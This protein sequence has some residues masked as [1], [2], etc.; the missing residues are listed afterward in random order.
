[1]LHQHHPPQSTGDEDVTEVKAVSWW[2]RVIDLY[3]NNA[4]STPPTTNPWFQAHRVIVAWRDMDAS[5]GKIEKYTNYN[6]IKNL[7]EYTLDGCS[8]KLHYIVHVKYLLKPDGGLQSR[9]WIKT[10]RSMTNIW[11]S[12]VATTKHSWILFK[13]IIKF[14]INNSFDGLKAHVST[15]KYTAL[16]HKWPKNEVRDSKSGSTMKTSSTCARARFN[17]RR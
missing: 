15:C 10:P 3:N 17:R 2:D 9:V 12:E 1:M 5:L 7:E 6:Y 8:W 16:S 13:I 14:K 4:P 11:Q